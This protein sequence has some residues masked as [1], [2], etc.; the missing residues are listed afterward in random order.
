[1]ITHVKRLMILSLLVSS[2]ATIFGVSLQAHQTT[3]QKLDVINK[4]ITKITEA[5]DRVKKN[6]PE[7]SWAF[8]HASDANLKRLE[9]EKAQLLGK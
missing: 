4:K 7:E 3:Q 2:S 9:A 6:D 8:I 1:M 5:I